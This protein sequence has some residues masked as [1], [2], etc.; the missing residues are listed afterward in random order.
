VSLPVVLYN[1]PGRCGVDLSMATLARLASIK[2]IVGIKE[3]TGTVQR[4]SEIA[5]RFGDRFTILSGDDAL[6]LPILAVG[7]HGVISVA[8]NVVPKEVS[9][10][11]DVFRAGDLAGARRQHQRLFDLVEA[12]F[13]EANPG[14]VKFAMSLRGLMSS[15]IRLPLVAPTEASQQHIQ[16]ALAGLG[17]T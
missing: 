3:A 14:P 5:K 16:H 10:L 1:I 15:E 17:A 9:Q 12:L 2:T 11:V 8:S 7:G 13:I 6:T 4:S